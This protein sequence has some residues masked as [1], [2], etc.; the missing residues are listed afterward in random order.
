[1]P[2]GA[3]GVVEYV[4]RACATLGDALAQWVRF[5]N[6]IDDAVQVALEGPKLKVVVESE[7][8]AG[9]SH[10]LCFA[11]VVRQAREL[12]GKPALVEHVR[13]T[14]RITAGAEKYTG[15]FGAPVS[16]SAKQTELVFAK[17]ALELPLTSAD[18]NLLAVL[19]PVALDEQKKR[20][21]GPPLLEQVRR[22]LQGALGSADAQLETVAKAL[23]MTPRS[24]QR[25]LKD[26]GVAFAELREQTRRRLA[27]Q[28]LRQDLSI[29][30]VSFLLGFSEPSAFFR[31]F[32]R[33]TGVT[34]QEHR[35]ARLSAAVR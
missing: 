9:A 18:P 34:P 14:H 12:T 21:K 17:H 19:V 15:W 13:F 31:A 29:A 20:P 30:E 25:K 16:F 23:S 27:D 10:E 7:A 28:Y 35:D 11:M 32:K 2:P 8:P 3:F 33:W 5:L 1:M 22:A 26:E 24:L 4:C 6:L